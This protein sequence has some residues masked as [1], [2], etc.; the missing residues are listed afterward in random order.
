MTKSDRTTVRE[1][2]RRRLLR[3]IAVTLIAGLLSRDAVAADPDGLTWLTVKATPKTSLRPIRLWRGGGGVPPA[4]G[5][6]SQTYRGNSQ[7]TLIHI[8][9]AHDSLEAQQ[10]I[11]GILET[12]ASEYDIRSV[13]IEGGNGAVNDAIFRSFPDAEG[14]RRSADRLMAEGLL[15]AGQYFA[16][17]TPVDGVR[18]NGAENEA[19]YRRNLAA[20]GRLLRAARQVETDISGLQRT[21]EAL[22]E[23]INN[24]ELQ[25]LRKALSSGPA[26]PVFTKKWQF[27]RQL[28]AAKGVS[29]AAYPNLQALTEVLAIES[30]IDFE[31]ANRQRQGLIE[32]FR[33]CLEPGEARQLLMKTLRFKAGRLSETDYHLLLVRLAERHKIDPKP[34]LNLIRYARYLSVYGTIEIERLM[35]ELNDYEER[36]REA[37]CRREDEKIFDQLERRARV[38][39]ALIRGEASPA[40][41]RVFKAQRQS[42]AGAE[43]GAALRALSLQ[44][45]VPLYH[46]WRPQRLSE[47]LAPAERFY[48]LAER[49]DRFLTAKA[50]RLMRAQGRRSGVLI[51]GGFH[52][53]GIAQSLRSRH[54]ACIAVLPKITDPLK[55]RPYVTLLTHRPEEYVRALSASSSRYTIALRNFFHGSGSASSVGDPESSLRPFLEQLPQEEGARLAA[56]KDWM[57]AYQR[58][59]HDRGPDWRP[60]PLTPQRVSQELGVNLSGARL[61]SAPLK[62]EQDANLTLRQW[63]AQ[64]GRELTDAVLREQIRRSIE[65]S[66]G[67]DFAGSEMSVHSIDAIREQE[68]AQQNPANRAFVIAISREP[69]PRDP[70][71]EADLMARYRPF[72]T[73]EEIYKHL[74]ERV[75][76]EDWKWFGIRPESSKA[77]WDAAMK[78]IQRRYPPAETRERVIRTYEARKQAYR[79]MVDCATKLNSIESHNPSLRKRIVGVSCFGDET[80]QVPW[81]WAPI[82]RRAKE[83]GLKISSRVGEKWP[84]DDVRGALLRVRSDIELGVNRLVQ[85]RVLAIVPQQGP[86]QQELILLQKQ[87]LETIRHRKIHVQLSSDERDT[88]RRLLDEGVSVSIDPAELGSSREAFAEELTRVWLA[89]P[90][91]PFKKIVQMIKDARTAR[92]FESVEDVA[93]RLSAERRLVGDAWRAFSGNAIVVFGSARIPPEH[94]AYTAAFLLGWQM[95][96]LNAVPRTGAGPSIMTAA[97]AGYI[98]AR[99]LALTGAEIGWFPTLDQMESGVS[100]YLRMRDASDFYKEPA[101]GVPY[102]LRT[103]GVRILLNFLELESDFSEILFS[104][105]HFVFR[106]LALYSKSAGVIAMPG[107]FGTLDEVFEAWKLELPLVLVGKNFWPPILEALDQSWKDA[108]LR[109]GI[110]NWPQVVD[111]KFGEAPS[112]IFDAVNFTPEPLSPTFESNAEESADRELA[113]ALQK[114]DRLPRPVA[115]LGNPAENG[116]PLEI[117]SELAKRLFKKNVPVRALSRGPVLERIVRELPPEDH[118]SLLQA[119]LVRHQG[120]PG[121]T[122]REQ[123]LRRDLPEQVILTDDSSNQRILGS[124][125]VKGLVVLPGGVGTLNRLFDLVVAMQTGKVRRRPVVLVDRVFWDPILEALEKA[126]LKHNPPMISEHDFRL[127]RVVDTAEEALSALGLGGARLA[128]D[129]QGAVPRYED[130][131]THLK[132]KSDSLSKSGG[133]SVIELGPEEWDQWWPLDRQPSSRKPWRIYGIC[134]LPDSEEA[135]DKKDA[136]VSIVAIYASTKSPEWVL[137]DGQIEYVS[138][139]DEADLH[140]KL[141]DLTDVPLAAESAHDLRVGS[142]FLDGAAIQI[143]AFPGADRQ[144]VI[145]AWT[146]A[147]CDSRILGRRLIVTPGPGMTTEDMDD[148]LKKVKE[149]PDSERVPHAVVGVS[150]EHG[151]ITRDMGSI[152]DALAA[153]INFF[154]LKKFRDKDTGPDAEGVSKVAFFGYTQKSL[155]ALTSLMD[156]YKSGTGAEIT[157]IQEGNTVLG[158]PPMTWTLLRRLNARLLSGQAFMDAA[159]EARVSKDHL[160]NLSSAEKPLLA[161][162]LK[163]A[164]LLILDAHPRSFTVEHADQFNGATVIEGAP[165]VA[166]AEA[167]SRL[168]E[169]QVIFV[170]YSSVNIARATLARQEVLYSA[171]GIQP[172]RTGAWQERSRINERTLSNLRDIFREIDRRGKKLWDFAEVVAELNQA[173]ISQIQTALEAEQLNPAAQRR[174]EQIRASCHNAALAKKIAVFEEVNGNLYIDHWAEL[175][176]ALSFNDPDAQRTAAYRLGSVPADMI[177]EEA[178]LQAVKALA[179]LLKEESAY[180]R[181]RA[182]AARALGRLGGAVAVEALKETYFDPKQEEPLVRQWIEWALRENAVDFAKDIEKLKIDIPEKRRAVAGILREAKLASGDREE[183]LVGI[184]GPLI[185]LGKLEYRLGAMYGFGGHLEEAGTWILRAASHFRESAGE[186]GLLPLTTLLYTALI[187]HRMAEARQNPQMDRTARKILLSILLS[188]KEQSVVG[189]SMREQ[190]RKSYLCGYFETLGMTY[191]RAVSLAGSMDDVLVEWEKEKKVRPESAEEVGIPDQRFEKIRALAEDYSIDPDYVRTLFLALADNRTADKADMIQT[192]IAGPHTFEP[193]AGARLASGPPAVSILVA[194]TDPRLLPEIRQ[195]IRGRSDVRL[196]ELAPATSPEELLRQIEQATAGYPEAA[197]V[198]LDGSPEQ[199]SRLKREFVR[200]LFQADIERSRLLSGLL[201]GRLR[202]EDLSEEEGRQCYDWMMAELQP[203]GRREL[204]EDVASIAKDMQKTLSDLRLRLFHA[205]FSESVEGLPPAVGKSTYAAVWS[206]EVVLSDPFFLT[207]LE[208]RDAKLIERYGCQPID[209]YLIVSQ[210]QFERLESLADARLGEGGYERLCARFNGRILRVATGS[211]VSPSETLGM[212][213]QS[214]DPSRV[215]VVDQARA[216][217]IRTESADK[218]GPG[219]LVLEGDSAWT[220]DKVVVQIL[221][222][223]GRWQDLRIKGLTLLKD[224]TL[225]FRPILSADFI[226]HLKQYSIGQTALST[227][228]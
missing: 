150:E 9:D 58:L 146:Q 75:R 193:D 132:K 219:L 202:P 141:L 70:A 134:A 119:V 71:A 225:L 168:K 103:Q 12:L 178:R 64:S 210:E 16:A 177:G 133:V 11:C 148:I 224:G 221:A 130:L 226:N 48:R 83:L 124:Y 108:G 27:L 142:S 106:K 37:C 216:R 201:A 173:E 161:D 228:A 120:T 115:I 203:M 138:S 14:A 41:Y 72:K 88:L 66:L 107:G 113:T 195:L 44:Y 47:A 180:Y 62:P 186:G 164:D 139:K 217:I 49:R 137:A 175:I 196:L 172:G 220:L 104:F 135:Q 208:D 215:L 2:R 73:I 89:D 117:L 61:A 17:T 129:P 13:F 207:T 30:T 50:L 57:I 15:D 187:K 131:L 31:S 1:G 109:E 90:D 33:T 43:F 96:K 163:A 152:G 7:E 227:S 167:V 118:D 123:R 82:L 93:K 111:F 81:V 51:T 38:V 176:A 56:I 183:S 154:A 76:Q 68:A 94:E 18:V 114:L 36:V 110:R 158:G 112:E 54:L 153:A 143:V 87:I 126:M 3:G 140:S 182:N 190:V 144:K 200:R 198:V 5:W 157:A 188:S 159:K 218:A 39:M 181:V 194:V 78:E 171:L 80:R 116:P 84:G 32:L 136:F 25:R 209:D 24:P 102:F 26:G 170:P 4:L 42:M 86:E 165:H 98:A 212:L 21:L 189:G 91:L 121:W 185:E 214:Y 179:E 199:A 10:K 95:W 223:G 29:E 59:C 127:L 22:S 100:A 28:G 197:I 160:H 213:G 67:P 40:E 211:V 23:R 85:P 46:G 174:F 53:P 79:R 128:D 145:R 122:A 192:L 74:L 166:T 77:E 147:L 69:D 105:S 162:P 20:F 222:A 19:L 169:K 156:F 155:S 149:N 6:T 151:G 206:L 125:G 45:H 205:S 52:S 101:A 55:K 184:Q 204:G 191:D 92:F 34:Y 65:E 97:L 8:Q 99:Q 35:A 60:G 63:A